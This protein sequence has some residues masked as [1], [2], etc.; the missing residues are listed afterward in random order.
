MPSVLKQLFSSEKFLY[1]LVLFMV[2]LTVFTA[3]GK[4]SIEAWRHDALWA[5]GFLVGGKTI[6]G[7][8]QSIGMGMMGPD[9]PP[10]PPKE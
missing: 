3:M 1:V 2:P 10:A 5:L 4:V 9:E 7:A 8:A 6:Q